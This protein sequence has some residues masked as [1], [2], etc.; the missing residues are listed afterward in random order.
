MYYV[1]EH[2]TPDGE[3]FYVGKGVNGRAY[4]HSKRSIAWKEKVEEADGIKEFVLSE[5]D[6]STWTIV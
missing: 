4:T 1:Y 3:I 2:S 6:G 5:A